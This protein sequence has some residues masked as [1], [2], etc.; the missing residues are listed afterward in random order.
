MGKHYLIILK[1]KSNRLKAVILTLLRT[2]KQNLRSSRNTVT[3]WFTDFLTNLNQYQRPKYEAPHSEHPET[4]QNWPETRIHANHAEA[5]NAS[6]RRRNSTYRRKT[7][8]YA[9]QK[10]MLQRTLDIYWIAHN[11]IRKQFTTKPVPAVALGIL[12]KGPSR[13]QVL[14]IQKLPGTLNYVNIISRLWKN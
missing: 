7:N 11:F 13:E 5:F 3:D 12:E 1:D 4:N 2:I 14:S 8:T 6:L 9:K 10:T